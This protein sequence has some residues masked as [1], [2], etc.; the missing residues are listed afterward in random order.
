MRRQTDTSVDGETLSTTHQHSGDVDPEA[1]ADQTPEDNASVSYDVALPPAFTMVV[2]AAAWHPSWGPKP[3][4]G[5]ELI[6]PRTQ[7]T[8]SANTQMT[9][10]ETDDGQPLKQSVRSISMGNYTNT[11]DGEGKVVGG[12]WTK[13]AGNNTFDKMAPETNY[14]LLERELAGDGVDLSGSSVARV[15]AA[16]AEK[17]EEEFRRSQLPSY[18][19]VTAAWEP[20]EVVDEP[21]VG[22]VQTMADAVDPQVSP[23]LAATIDEMD[24]DP[25]AETPQT[26]EQ[27]WEDAREYTMEC[28]ERR[29][30]DNRRAVREM[31]VTNEAQ[32]AFGRWGKDGSG[33]SPEMKQAR[34]EAPDHKPVAF[35]HL[36]ARPLAGF[37]P[38]WGAVEP[39]TETWSVGRDATVEVATDPILPMSEARERENYFR[40]Q[41]QRME[42]N[43]LD[44]IESGVVRLIDHHATCIGLDTDETYFA[45]YSNTDT[46]AHPANESA[47]A[48][49]AQ[50]GSIV[51]SK[52]AFAL[53]IPRASRARE[54][55]ERGLI[56]TRDP[57]E[58]FGP[59]IKWVWHADTT[60]SLEDI[61]PSWPGAT[62][63]ARVADVYVPNHPDTQQQ[64]V[65]LE[66]IAP[67][68]A[69]DGQIGERA[70]LT[71]FR[72]S[73]I[74][75][76]LTEGDIA[77]VGNPKPGVYNDRLTLAATGNTTI[78][79]ALPSRGPIKSH[80]TVLGKLTGANGDEQRVGDTERATV[81]GE[82]DPE[83]DKAVTRLPK[84]RYRRVGH[85]IR[86]GPPT[87]GDTFEIDS[88]RVHKP[89]REKACPMT[90]TFPVPEWAESSIPDETAG[91]D[92]DGERA[93]R[94][95]EPSDITDD[96][97]VDI[98]GDEFALALEA[99][100]NDLNEPVDQQGIVGFN[101]TV[102]P[103]A[104]RRELV[105]HVAHHPHA[106]DNREIRVF[107]GIGVIEGATAEDT[108][109][110]LP[111]GEETVRFGPVTSDDAG[112]ETIR[113]VEWD[114]DADEPVEVFAPITHTLAWEARLKT[115]IRNV[116][117][118]QFDEDEPSP[119]ALA[120]ETVTVSKTDD[121][122][123][124]LDTSSN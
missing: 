48:T 31:N 99:T 14:Q 9:I 19:D 28:A 50:D 33:K 124:V 10:G 22:P 20:E 88:T 121:G 101:A 95:T 39:E 83:A 41:R 4:T 47:S 114:T 91:R 73:Y 66:D 77:F 58:A 69:G 45:D 111:S 108:Q 116:R 32:P 2:N 16:T 80:K 123:P 89:A 94:S 18:E 52:E 105:G 107:S 3:V 13:A 79:R 98:S 102:I 55:Y 35:D 17:A 72:E 6:V 30:Q 76:Y 82:I 36:R 113:V 8:L 78:D 115:L 53:G 97:S 29:A 118:R 24:T 38:K 70:K 11:P 119:E 86:R 25:G 110:T 46:D 5:Y 44:S 103:D 27:A 65:Y 74:D 15:E 93:S 7:S 42:R 37:D 57:I 106:P 61:E 96:I 63:K 117:A 120:S 100:D 122:T 49:V 109:V 104:E 1:V 71:V 51:E 81:E 64:V 87:H 26:P 43:T 23:E 60:H 21:E 12:G 84:K 62:V 112:S 75:T 54:G 56:H 67:S 90:W 34:M 85:T 92:T 59:A 68:P 40:Q